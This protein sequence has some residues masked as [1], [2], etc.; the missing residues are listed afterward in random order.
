MV[1]VIYRCIRELHDIC[2]KERKVDAKYTL[3]PFI[4]TQ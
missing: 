3:G 2:G 1:Y 4:N